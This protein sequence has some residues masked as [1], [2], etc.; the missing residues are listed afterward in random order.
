M[1]HLIDEKGRVA[2]GCLDGPVLFNHETFPLRNFFGRKV[3]ALGRR[4]ALGSFNYLGIAGDGFLVGLAAVRLGYLANVF[5]F[6]F[7]F[8]TGRALQALAPSM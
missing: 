4:M 3:G 1:H 5:G 2:Y 6:H 8:A 7:D